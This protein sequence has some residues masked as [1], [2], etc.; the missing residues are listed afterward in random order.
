MKTSKATTTVL[1]REMPL[2]DNKLQLPLEF[3]RDHKFKP[4]DTDG[5]SPPRSQLLLGFS[6]YDIYTFETYMP[7][8]NTGVV[9]S[10]LDIATGRSPGNIYIWGGAGV[11]KSHL[12]QAVCNSASLSE[13]SCAYIP[14][15]QLDELAPEMFSSLEELDLVCLDD[16][17]EAAGNDSWETVLFDLFNRLKDADIPLVMS[18]DRSPKGSR[19]RLPDLKSRLSWGLGFHI[20]PLD[21]R[22]K[23]TALKLRARER[24]FELTDQVVEFLVNR[25]NRDTH[26]LFRWL[27]R[28]DRHSLVEQ[29]KL[30]VEFVKEI[31][32]V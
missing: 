29:R 18:S 27:D 31:L 19:V 9:E 5:G 11:G 25:V 14:M 13:R 23:I 7:G 17:E 22:M 30:T 15:T 2:P 12:L 6:R 10:L 8:T 3:N 20:R 21:D 1:F 16:I 24:G 32:R 26:N 4:L 28:L